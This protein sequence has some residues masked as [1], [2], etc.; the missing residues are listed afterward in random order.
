MRPNKLRAILSSGGTA[1]G[2]M[3]GEVRNPSIAMIFA[4][5]GFDYVFVDM[6]HGPYSL[7]TAADILRT[8]RLTGMTALVRAPDAQYHLIAR[9]MDAGAEGVMVPRVETREAAEVVVSA[10]RYPP[11][12]VRGLS[13]SKGHN[14]FTSA[15]SL[16]FTRQANQENLVILQ[17]ERKEAIE[18]IDD[19]LSVP[20]VD[21]AIIGPIDLSVSLG[22]P[23]DFN[24]PAMLEAIIKVVE[25]GARHGVWVGMHTGG[26]GPLVDWH[27]KGMRLITWSTD[28][29]MLNKAS[30]GGL[31]ELKKQ[32]GVQ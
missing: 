23:T 29:D 3:I 26:I 25:A 4:N 17:I 9:L 31:A 8:A 16:E 22:V 27:R 10:V 19:L 21:A 11:L 12:G 20:G 6:E 28:I 30:A 18:H 5:A 24:H 1:F 2:T 14:D 32:I 7:E 13:T 15:P